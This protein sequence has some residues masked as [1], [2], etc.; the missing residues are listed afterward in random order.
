MWP[1][2]RDRSGRRWRSH[3]ENG[4]GWLVGAS[5]GQFLMVTSAGVL[6]EIS[7][8]GEKNRSAGELF[9]VFKRKIEESLKGGTKTR[10]VERGILRR[11]RSDP[12]DVI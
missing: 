3:L 12:L 6:D 10:D 1:E 4:W 8:T 5:D 2:P 7:G 9:K 11:V